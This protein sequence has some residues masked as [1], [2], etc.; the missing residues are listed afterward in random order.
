MSE[1]KF[2]KGPWEYAEGK[3]GPRYI[4]DDQ[5]FGMICTVAWIE[6]YEGQSYYNHEANAHLI[7]AAPGLYEALET[8]LENI[9][10]LGPA[11]ALYDTYKP[12]EELVESALRK[13]RGEE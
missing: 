4:H 12:W 9:R 13:A 5:S 6:K 7:A 11:G 8:T 3:V 10:S 1:K 2:A